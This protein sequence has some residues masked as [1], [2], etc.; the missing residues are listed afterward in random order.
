M[1][2]KFYKI[3]FT[4]EN[5]VFAHIMQTKDID[6]GHY[7]MLWDYFYSQNGLVIEINGEKDYSENMMF[8]NVSILLYED[9]YDDG[10]ELMRIDDVELIEMDPEKVAMFV[11]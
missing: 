1:E 7:E 9:E 5:R 2:N 4:H 8:D 6:E 10:E 11:F 3:K